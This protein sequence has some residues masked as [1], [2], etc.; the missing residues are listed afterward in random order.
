MPNPPLAN[1]RVAER[2]FWRSSQSGVAGGQQPI[3]N[4]YR[5]LPFLLH[6]WQ[7]PLDPL[8]GKALSATRGLA[9]GGLG[10]RQ[11]CLIKV[12]KKDSAQTVN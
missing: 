2:A 4:P 12:H 3:G 11:R 8:V 6:T 10:T 9:P 7:H 1:P 5:F